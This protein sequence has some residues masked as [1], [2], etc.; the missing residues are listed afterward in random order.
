MLARIRQW[1]QQ[2][3]RSLSIFRP[4]EAPARAEPEPAPQPMI[5]ARNRTMR[6]V[7]AW[8]Y[9]KGNGLEIGALHGPLPLPPNVRASYVDRLTVEELRV[10]YPELKNL[11][12]VP[13]DIIDDGEKLNSVPD[14]SQDF[15]IASHFIEHTQD[16]IGT[17]KRFLAVLKPGG[18]LYL[19]VP[20]K[21]GTFDVRRQLTTLEHLYRD[22]EE[23][24][25]WSYEAHYYDMVEGVWE[26]RPK[27]EIEAEAKRL[28]AIEYSIHFH[29]WT[30]T[31]FWEMLMA[32]R[33][34]YAMPFDIYSLFY[35]E[36]GPESIVVLAKT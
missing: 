11:P 1:R 5:W 21:R 12:L 29:V 18:I 13:L 26:N 4:E 28:M 30:H 7:I 32:I 34:R 25:A 15:V 3:K 31:T 14:G 35:N 23:G 36:P 24:P 9:L 16:P 10:H 6:E 20:D 22:H 17:I 33:T 19:V 2:V 8:E 27:E